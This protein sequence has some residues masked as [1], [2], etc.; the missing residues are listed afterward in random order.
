MS[1]NDQR[2]LISKSTLIDSL[3]LHTTSASSF[4]TS[5]IN[6]E[7]TLADLLNNNR[8]KAIIPTPNRPTIVSQS[9][10]CKNPD[11][12]LT[13][14]TIVDNADIESSKTVTKLLNS[15]KQDDMMGCTDNPSEPGE[16]E[17][18]HQFDSF[19][20]EHFVPFSGKQ[21]VNLWLDETESKFNQ[22]KI[23]R[24]FR[25][26]AISLLVEGDAKR[27]YIKNRKAIRSFDDF[28]EFLLVHFDNNNSSSS[29]IKSQAIYIP[30]TTN[31]QTSCQNESITAAQGKSIDI[32]D[33]I[34]STRHSPCHSTAV[35]D[36]HTT[37]IISDTLDNK[38]G[39]L[40]TNSSINILDQTTNDLRKAIVGDLIRNPK[41]FKGG[42]DDVNKWIEEI[43]HLLDVAHIPDSS[44]LDIISYSLRG[45]ALQWYKAN[46][47]MFTSWII[48]VYELKRAFTSSFHEELAFKKLETYTQGDSQS[49][50]N[51]F[52]KVL[53]LCK[54]ADPNMSEST[55]LKHLLNKAKPTIQ[56]EVRKKKPTTIT[57]FFEYAK[58]V[59]EWY[60]LSNI[61]IDNNNKNNNSPTTTQQQ[62]SPLMTV[63]SS[64]TTY[65]NKPFSNKFTSDYS[66]NFN[67]NNNNTFRNQDNRNSPQSSAFTTSS[68]RLPQ[69]AQFQ[70]RT[71]TQRF[72]PNKNN[73]FFNS[74]NANRTRPQQYQPNLSNI[75]RRRQQAANAISPSDSTI[76]PDLHSETLPVIVCTQCNEF[77]HEASTCPNF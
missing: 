42:K 32:P 11:D 59:E 12:E 10:T 44:R 5:T 14:N 77:G 38:P 67:N 62:I 52:N 66:R 68:F 72:Q 65:S 47:A 64:S 34:N 45:D 75:D 63:P 26:E 71:T 8:R 61:N 36:C 17:E 3:N 56:F 4:L 55:K 46:K 19:V 76:I 9:I 35:A 40:T 53:Q 6:Q 16:N 37:S 50:R 49:I 74:N 2:P 27:L 39:N 28:Y 18:D 7:A 57:E 43:E 48:F 41:V 1:N 30:D 60:Q 23:S 70:P 20:L 21:P 51:F 33:T 58:D 13:T 15:L 29:T 73:S 24:S 69:A 31:Q 54:E 25:F 22:F